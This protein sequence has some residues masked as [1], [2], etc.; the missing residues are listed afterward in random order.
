LKKL[1]TFIIKTYIGPFVLTLFIA[2]FLLLMQFLWKYID[3]LVGKGFD[4]S[5]I[6]ELLMYASA[7]LIPL[8]LP[9]AVLLSSLLTFG[10][11]GEHNELMAL[12]ASG[13]S[14]WRILFPLQ[15]FMVALS[16]GA[17]V[18]MNNVLPVTNL[19]MYALLYSVRHQSPEVSIEAG[20]FN[21]DITGYSIKVHEKDV[22]TGMF[23]DVMIYDHSD[24]NGNRIVTKADSGTMKMTDDN[25][26]MIFTLYH[27]QTY[28][29]VIEKKRRN[30][31]K[32]YPHRTNKFEKQRL[33][34]DMSAMKFERQDE[35]LFKNSYQMLNMDQ[36]GYAS[37][38]L[39]KEY[40]IRKANLVDNLYRSNYYKKLLRTSKDSAFLVRATIPDTSVMVD[41]VFD[42]M[43]YRE[44][45]LSVENAMNYARGTKTYLSNNQSEFEF[46]QT[47]INKHKNEWHR[48]MV[49]SIS[50]LLLFFIGAPLGAIIRKGGL[51]L[52]VVVSVIM[53]VIYYVIS[54][55]AEKSARA[56]SFDPWFGMWFSSFI[57]LPFGIMLTYQAV[58]DSTILSKEAYMNFFAKVFGFI[59]RPLKSKFKK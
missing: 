47:R 39:E 31:D 34:I 57:V 22:N 18:F 43:G 36:L 44:K 7:G 26:N 5:V 48:K 14:L 28:Q 53:F 42:Q 30:R 41:S 17:F 6:A 11:L 21:N 25:M 54:M 29:E 20:V 55:S 51:G 12:K 52:P 10:N 56:G 33:L 32:E 59:V 4:V 27:G 40:R 16:I 15:V 37:D 58:N 50:C 38:S 8:S 1:H 2:Q 23:Y 9:L 46:K 19:K 45:I 35:S 49:V 13:I 24:D 3:D